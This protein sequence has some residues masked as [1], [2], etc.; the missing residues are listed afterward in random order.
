MFYLCN[1]L[2][3]STQSD[4]HKEHGWS[5]EE[6]DGALAGSLSHGYDEDH[7]GVD[8]GNRGGQHN[9]HVHVGCAVF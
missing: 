7:A 1:V 2:Q 5:V 4:E 9:Q 6:G 3:P 8:V